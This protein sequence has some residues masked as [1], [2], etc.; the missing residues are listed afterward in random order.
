MPC[1][2]KF[3]VFR[4]HTLS[5]ILYNNCY[6]VSLFAN[7]SLFFIVLGE[8]MAADADLKVCVCVFRFLFV[9]VLLPFFGSRKE[10]IC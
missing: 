2:G 9:S 5:G 1:Y 8:L 6:Y 10:I 7:I 3:V 4:Y